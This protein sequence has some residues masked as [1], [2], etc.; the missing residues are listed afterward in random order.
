MMHI[1]WRLRNLSLRAVGRRFAYVEGNK[2][3]T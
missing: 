1:I 3:K 2:R